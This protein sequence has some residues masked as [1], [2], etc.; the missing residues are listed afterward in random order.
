MSRLRL[1]SVLTVLT[2][3]CALVAGPACAT[4]RIKDI[5]A[6]EGV[7]DNQ[8]IG[9]GIVVGLDGSGDQTTQTPFTVQS[10]VSMLQSKGVNLPAGTSLQLKNVAAVMVTASLPAICARLALTATSSL[11]WVI[12]TTIASPLD[13]SPRWTRLSPATPGISRYAGISTS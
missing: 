7:R 6:F 3:V 9:Y 11:T 12:I 10:I 1:S 2:A 8:L 5:V 13:D 4:S